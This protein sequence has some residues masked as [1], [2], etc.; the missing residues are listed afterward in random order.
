MLKKVVLKELLLFY[1][2]WADVLHARMLVHHVHACCLR[3]PEEAVRSP[4]TGGA[5]G[6][7]PLYGSWESNLGSLKEQ[8]ELI[9]TNL[10]LFYFM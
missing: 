2:M 5:D 3:R 7:E 10:F 8:P 9:T 1:F 6:C 4:E